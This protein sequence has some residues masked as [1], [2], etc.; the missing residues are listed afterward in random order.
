MYIINHYEGLFDP[1]EHAQHG[2][3]IQH[4]EDHVRV[5]V[6]G[7]S[8]YADVL[9]YFLFSLRPLRPIE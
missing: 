5:Q 9:F 4:V 2:F 8:C 7:Y 1:F 6:D 3:S